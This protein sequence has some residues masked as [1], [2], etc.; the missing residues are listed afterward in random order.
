MA[1]L[2]VR[3][4]DEKLK[5]LLRVRAA[6]NKRSMEDEIRVILRQAA[7]ETVHEP[8]APFGLRSPP[9]AQPSR[10]SATYAG[11]KRIVLIIGFATLPVRALL[12]AVVTDPILVVAVQFL[13]GIASAAFLIMV[14]LVTA[15]I[16][17][18]SGHFN[19]ALGFVGFT[20]GLGGVSSTTVAGWVTDHYGEAATFVFLAAVGLIATLLVWLALP[21]T[22]PAATRPDPG[23]HRT[24]D[25]RKMKVRSKE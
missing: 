7:Q 14:P 22:K 24:A 21:E 6:R 9:T 4:L 1:S 13:N 23:E 11:T 17:G 20:I 5:T 19:L 15:D 10:A 2:T 12:F 8:P 3:Q 18:R 25:S 16:A